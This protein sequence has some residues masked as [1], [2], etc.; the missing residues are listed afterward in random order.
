MPSAPRSLSQHFSSAPL[1]AQHHRG[2]RAPPPPPSK[3]MLAFFE[4]FFQDKAGCI[5]PA[6]RPV[7]PGSASHGAHTL[8]PR[9]RRDTVPSIHGAKPG[10]NARN[11]ACKSTRPSRC[12]AP[13]PPPTVGAVPGSPVPH[14]VES[15]GGCLPKTVTCCQA[16]SGPSQAHS[17]PLRAPL[18]NTVMQHFRH[19]P[20]LASLDTVR[21]RLTGG[22]ALSPGEGRGGGVRGQKQVCAPEIN[23][24]VRAP[25]INFIFFRGRS[26]LVCVGGVGEVRR[27]SPGCHSAPP[28]PQ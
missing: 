2:S 7:M 17:L 10:R 9:F 19:L 14:A 13:P 22:R 12:C 18:Y 16:P 1:K 26:F 28:R 24:Q 15:R 4:S 25:L 27:R 6:T 21:P 20:T 23:P 11:S 5:S 8:G 3:D